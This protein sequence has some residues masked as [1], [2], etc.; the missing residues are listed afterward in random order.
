MFASDMTTIMYMF[1]VNKSMNTAKFEFLI[2]IAVNWEA[3]LLKV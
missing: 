3:N 1:G 2:S